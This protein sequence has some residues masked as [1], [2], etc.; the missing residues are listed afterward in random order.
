LGLVPLGSLGMGLTSVGLYLARGSY[1]WSVGALALL[2]VT[3]GL[4]IVPL[5]AF[6][7][8]RAG[9][10]QKGRAIATN[11][12]HNTV[13]LLLAQLPP[14][15]ER[16]WRENGRFRRATLVFSVEHVSKPRNSD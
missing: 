4:F 5:N 6:L 14:T 2:G 16:W 15:P 3:A 8:Q 12:F 9:A 1:A 7:Q 10:A 11:N 13:G